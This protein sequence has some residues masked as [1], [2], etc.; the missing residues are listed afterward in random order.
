MARSGLISELVLEFSTIWGVGQVQTTPNDLFG[1]ICLK[2]SVLTSTLCHWDWGKIS[3][4]DRQSS[5]N[6]MKIV[7]KQ[8]RYRQ[9]K[10]GV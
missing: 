4:D 1:E 8:P 2:P 10:F 6:T 3:S 9:Y 7:H 5:E